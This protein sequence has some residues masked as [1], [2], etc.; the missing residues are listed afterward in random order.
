MKPEKS[1][2]WGQNL[3]TCDRLALSDAEFPHL[4][5]LSTHQL[6]L[7]YEGEEHWPPPQAATCLPVKISTGVLSCP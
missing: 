2:A 1:I 7:G 4:A 3:G 5:H 6:A